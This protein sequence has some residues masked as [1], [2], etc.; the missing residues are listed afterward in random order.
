MIDETWT[1]L[2]LV[3]NN[4]ILEFMIGFVSF[5]RTS[6]WSWL[7]IRS[8]QQFNEGK[9]QYKYIWTTPFATKGISYCTIEKFKQFSVSLFSHLS[10]FLYY[11][12]A[13]FRCACNQSCASQK[14]INVVAGGL[15]SRTDDIVALLFE[16]SPKISTVS[17]KR[18]K[19]SL[20]ECIFTA[21][22]L[23]SF[24]KNMQIH[25]FLEIKA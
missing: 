16:P 9:N 25:N 6:H 3:S 24:L 5:L 13:S 20:E 19:H 7:N 23:I 12:H 15:M 14:Q 11:F 1:Y 22:V 8:S 17:N 18:K 21:F 4:T 2:L 10:L